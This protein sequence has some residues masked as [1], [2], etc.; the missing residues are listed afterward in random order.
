MQ[1]AL[2]QEVRCMWNSA[3]MRVSERQ[4]IA[5]GQSYKQL[6]VVLAPQKSSYHNPEPSSRIGFG[7]DHDYQGGCSGSSKHFFEERS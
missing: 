2:L 7:K 4:P 3:A 1:E 5:S 6:C